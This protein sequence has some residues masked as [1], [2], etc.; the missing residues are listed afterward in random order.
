MVR[1]EVCKTL[2]AQGLPTT[3]QLYQIPESFKLNPSN[4]HNRGIYSIWTH[5]IEFC[6][7]INKQ[8]F[9][10]KD[11]R[12]VNVEEDNSIFEKN[13]NSKENAHI[14]GANRLKIFVDLSNG[15]FKADDSILSTTPP[16]PIPINEGYSIPCNSEKE[17]DKKTIL[18][19][20][21]TNGLGFNSYNSSSNSIGLTDRSLSSLSTESLSDFSQVFEDLNYMNLCS[22][23]DYRENDND[24]TPNTY[25]PP[26]TDSSSEVTMTYDLFGTNSPWPFEKQR[27]RGESFSSLD[28]SI[29]SPLDQSDIT[30]P[31]K[32]FNSVEL[33][34][35]N[36]ENVNKQNKSIDMA[37]GR[38]GGLVELSMKNFKSALRST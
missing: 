27:Q 20:L 31:I 30:K 9:K 23:K 38:P 21:V 13:R 12:L 34:E 6:M 5:F 33:K 18:D 10:E 26:K 1:K 22:E 32:E 3:N 29:E 2:D 17:T 24:K 4:F 7:H 14:P 8:Q 16:C 35:C 15:T 11:H 28:E 19:G 36:N 25:S 37:V